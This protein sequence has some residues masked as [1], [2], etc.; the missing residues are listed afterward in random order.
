MVTGEGGTIFPGPG[1]ARP[2]PA[3]LPPCPS[4]RGATAL[5]LLPVPGELVVLGGPGL[6][7]L[8][9]STLNEHIGMKCSLLL[10]QKF[11]GLTLPL[12]LFN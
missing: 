4:R 5:I 12:P 3:R 2:G 9:D 1:P 6:G 8:I 11:K 10:S 7:R